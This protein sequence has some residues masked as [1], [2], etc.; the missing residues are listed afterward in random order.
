MLPS[1]FDMLQLDHHGARELG[2]LIVAATNRAL[3]GIP[4]EQVPYH[5]CWGSWNAP[6]AADIELVDVIDLVYR[7]NAQTY[8]VEAANARHD[9]EWRVFEKYRLPEGKMLMPGVVS[10]ATNVIEHPQGV[11]DRIV[12]FADIVGRENV[13]ASSDCGFRSASAAPDQPTPDR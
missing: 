10:H 11:A 3:E 5:I 13:V 12:R 2:E 8:S 4:A 7:V 6:H 1:V 9:H